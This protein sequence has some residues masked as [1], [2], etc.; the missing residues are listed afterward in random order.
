MGRKNLI[1][2]PVRA[3]HSGDKLSIFIPGCFP[4]ASPLRLLEL[5]TPDCCYIK[6]FR[7]KNYLQL[8]I[9]DR[10]FDLI[11]QK[12]DRFLFPV[13]FSPS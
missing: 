3:K 7:I 11:S 6:I 13:L 10:T 12:G 5:L 1:L 2:T 4:N 8:K 9:S